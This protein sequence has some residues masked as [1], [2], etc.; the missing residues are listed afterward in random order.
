M[1]YVFPDVQHK[2]IRCLSGDL[3]KT[4][5]YSGIEICS[6][7]NVEDT[8]HSFSTFKF[9]GWCSGTL[10]SGEVQFLRFTDDKCNSVKVSIEVTVK[11]NHNWALSCLQKKIKP[12][13]FN[14]PEAM[15]FNL[16]VLSGVLRCLSN[17]K[18]CHG[19]PS[20]M[21]PQEN[22]IQSL[23]WQDYDTDSPCNRFHSAT[24]TGVVSALASG[25]QC[26]SCQKY[27]RYL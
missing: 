12:S 6:M 3:T 21:L 1:K 5:L 16:V 24:C 7:K 17:L 8:F 9:H 14:L 11:P 18:V 13:A 10:P 19:I 25:R 22:N 27:Q 26:R 4:G 15:P 2:S 20:Q 23:V